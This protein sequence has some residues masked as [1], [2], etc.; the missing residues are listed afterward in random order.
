M[1]LEYL[2]ILRNVG[3][4]DDDDDEDDYDNNNNDELFCEMVDRQKTLHLIFMTMVDGSYHHK[5]PTHQEKDLNQSKT[6][7]QTLS[8]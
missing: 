2:W 1:Y 6:C 3:D 7:V 8:N 5:P 4:N